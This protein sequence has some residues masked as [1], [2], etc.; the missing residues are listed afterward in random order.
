MSDAAADEYKEKLNMAG[1]EVFL[2]EG[3]DVESHFLC[4]DH[5]VSVAPEIS[6]ETA[7]KLIDEATIECREKS[8]ERCINSWVTEAQQKKNKGGPSVN[9]GKIA[10]EA[11]HAYNASPERYRYGK[12]VRGV[13]VGKLQKELGRNVEL[14]QSS[15]AIVVPDLKRIAEEVAAT[16]DAGGSD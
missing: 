5:V 11:G 2:T 3:T 7:V 10:T 6:R 16:G 4:P 1:L 9:H 15:P 13:L 14:L 8:V 12:S